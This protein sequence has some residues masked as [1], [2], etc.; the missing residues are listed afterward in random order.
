MS[1]VKN[2]DIVWKRLASEKHEKFTVKK[3]KAGSKWKS[4]LERNLNCPGVY[5]LHDNARIFY[6]GIS[7]TGVMK[8]RWDPTKPSSHDSGKKR[9]NGEGGKWSTQGKFAAGDLKIKVKGSDGKVKTVT[10]LLDFYAERKINPIKKKRGKNRK[11]KKVSLDKEN[12]ISRIR[13]FENMLIRKGTYFHRFGG[14]R[15]DDVLDVNRFQTSLRKL[16]FLQPK[17]VL[18]VGWT[19]MNKSDGIPYSNKINQNGTLKKNN[20]TKKMNQTA[21]KLNMKI[22]VKGKKNPTTRLFKD[23]TGHQ[24][25]FNSDFGS[26]KKIR[27]TVSLVKKSLSV[28]T[29][30]RSKA[31]GSHGGQKKP[32]KPARKKR[33]VRKTSTKSSSQYSSRKNTSNKPKK[34]PLRKDLERAS[35]RKKKPKTFTSDGQRYTYADWR[36]P[37]K[38]KPIRKNS[39]R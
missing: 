3:W 7:D 32:S 6:I 9:R 27:G 1:R 26:S 37:K 2:K 36:L 28:A 18:S 10:P 16:H 21:N 4:E 31:L 11:V 17:T 30:S 8:N 22:C 5:C 38:G 29:T 14:C 19:M 34:P 23:Y 12:Q 33:S 13:F 15:L 39:N 35:S 20:A 25:I 24:A